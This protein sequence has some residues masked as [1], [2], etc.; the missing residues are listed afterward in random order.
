MGLFV[1]AVIFISTISLIFWVIDIVRNADKTVL[2]AIVAALGAVFSLLFTWWK[3]KQKSLRE[4]HREKKIEI[5]SKFFD[6]MFDLMDKS[7]RGLDSDEEVIKTVSS[8]WVDLTR[9]ILFYGSPK[10]VIAF[11][12]VRKGSN[13]QASALD[14]MRTIGRVIL[15][16]REDIGLSNKGLDELSVHQIYVNDDLQKMGI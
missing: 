9:G 15:A 16:M 13:E 7:K 2:A 3:E 8:H 14:T 12:S 10:V 1:A 6:L 4:A 5:Y 11:S